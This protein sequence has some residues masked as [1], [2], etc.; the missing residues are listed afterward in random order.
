[1]T[2]PREA[3]QCQVKLLG[4]VLNAEERTQTEAVAAGMGGVTEV[5]NQ[6]RLM[7]SSKLFASAK[8]S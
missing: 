2:G 1:L 7:A 8:Y 6:L 5:D 3:S 4:I